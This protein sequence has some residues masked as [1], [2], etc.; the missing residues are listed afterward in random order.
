MINKNKEDKIIDG[1]VGKSNKIAVV[2]P[3]IT[4]RHPIMIEQIT[5]CIGDLLIAREL[6]AGIMSI[7]VIKNIPTILKEIATN[8][9]N[10]IEKLNFNFFMFI[11]SA[12]SNSG[13]ML[14]RTNFDQL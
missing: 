9:A 11:P 14:I 13:L 6:A 12:C 7:A 3:T 4:D 5:I 2:T 8:R 1:P 10:I